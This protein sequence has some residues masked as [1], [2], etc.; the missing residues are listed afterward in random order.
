MRCGTGGTVHDSRL[1]GLAAERER[2]Q[3][4]GA[5]VE[6]QQLHDRQRQR[7]RAA[8]E[9]EDDERRH[10]RRSVGEDV[11]DELA[12][13]VVDPPPGRDGGDD[14]REV[15]VGQDHRRRLAGHFR[16]GFPHRDADV[17]AAKRRR[18]IDAVAGHRDDVVLGA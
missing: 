14:R 16:A 15:V 18:V 6:G 10:L 7:D 2:R 1:G 11:D 5:D 9:G 3:G 4:L 12:D 8:G 13:V 17:G